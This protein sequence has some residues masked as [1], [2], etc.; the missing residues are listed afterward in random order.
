M[1]KAF[2]SLILL[3][4]T[5]LN[6]H[7]MAPSSSCNFPFR[8]PHRKLR[9]PRVSPCATPHSPSRL[10]PPPQ[11]QPC[12][13]LIGKPGKQQRGEHQPSATSRIR[14]GGAL[15]CHE[16]IPRPCRRSTR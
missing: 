14:R 12:S 10:S 13:R 8:S 3:Y 2:Q 16:S 1:L 4:R 5:N 9:N 6:L 15:C 11:H 7:P